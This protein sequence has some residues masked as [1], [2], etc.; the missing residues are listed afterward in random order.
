MGCQQGSGRALGTRYSVPHHCVLSLHGQEPL[1]A[2]V[3]V[4][5]AF[6]GMQVRNS[7]M[8]VLT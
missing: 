1:Q 2:A 8:D 4:I 3:D 6:Q 5:S 7:P